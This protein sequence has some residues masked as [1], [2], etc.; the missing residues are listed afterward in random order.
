MGTLA[1]RITN[2]Y[3]SFP[4]RNTPV[5]GGVDLDIAD[6]EFLVVLGT[7]GSGKSTLLR[8]VAGLEHLDGGTVT[9]PTSDDDTRPHTGVVFQQPFLMPWLTVREN[10]AFGGRFAAH[11]DRFDAAYADELLRMFGLAD[12]AGYYPDQLSGGQAQRVAVIR[13]V[14]VRPRLLLLDEP[15][16]ALDP[17]IRS[18]LQVWLRDLARELGFTTVLVTHDIDEALLLADRIALLGGGGAV[19]QQWHLSARPDEHPDHLRAE[20][21]ARYRDTSLSSR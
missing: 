7:S 1:V 11:R 2:G 12:L 10:I 14:A 13:A 17:A 4:G 15:F 3:K 6:G 18:D 16:S 8:I 5:L 9:W 21:L 20:I 19:Q